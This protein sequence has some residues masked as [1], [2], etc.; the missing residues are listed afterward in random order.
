MEMKRLGTRERKIVRTHGPGVEQGMWRKR[1]AQLLRE[2]YRDLDL[3]AD[4]KKKRMEWIGHV[5]RMDH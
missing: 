5:V 4:I 2:L 1:T 3:V